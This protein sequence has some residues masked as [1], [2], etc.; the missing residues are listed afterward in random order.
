M[1]VVRRVPARTGFTLI[2]LLIVIAIIALLISILM[3]GLNRAREQGRRA[4]CLGSL[5]NIGTAGA[6]Y[7]NSEPHELIIPIH[8]R[9]VSLIGSNRYWLR[10][11]AMW[12]SWGGRSGQ[13]PFLAGTAAN[14][15]FM[16]NQTGPNHDGGRWA[17]ATRPMNRY[18]FRDLHAADDAEMRLFQCPSDVGY[19]AHPD[20]DDSP[21]Q[22][23]ERPCYDTLGNSYR[24]NLFGY[25]RPSS[26]AYDGAIS[27]GPWGH[28]LS[29][30][31]DRSQL[32]AYGEPLFFN[33]IGQDATSQPVIIP[34]W[35]GQ[36][37][38]E[39][40]LFC[41][42]SARPTSAY[43]LMKIDEQT[44]QAMNIG[45]NARF[46]ARGPGWRF[47]TW[48]LPGARIWSENPTNP[49]WN[50]PFSAFSESNGNKHWPFV[51]MVNQF[52]NPD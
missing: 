22:N 1:P 44:A 15:Q 40:L 39:N 28:R 49:Y 51:G 14:Q 12:F 13:I 27:F 47:D 35:H 33:M 11:T 46:T 17:A 6:S 26:Q 38:T 24:A 5:R 41:D 30:L 43:G 2:E 3:P 23:A 16:L 45:P 20:I 19:P 37:M 52:G 31:P 25:Y 29:S 8:E 34:G 48:P 4:V 36:V 18:L 10:R 9:M 42:G 7:A 21:P 50:P 32:V